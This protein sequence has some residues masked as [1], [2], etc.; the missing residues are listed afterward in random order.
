[1]P[2][3]LKVVE[4]LNPVNPEVGNVLPNRVADD[5]TDLYSVSLAMHESL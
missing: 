1:M 4:I 5:V 3:A 2:Q